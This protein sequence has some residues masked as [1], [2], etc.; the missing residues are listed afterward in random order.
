M[1]NISVEELKSKMDSGENFRLV[2]VREPQ[3]N[4]EYNIG[5]T[6]LPLGNIMGMQ[7]DPIENYK[8][9]EVILYCRSGNRSGQAAM[10]LE[11]MGFKNV[12]NLA[13]GMLAW[14]ERIDLGQ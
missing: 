8:D 1:Q 14:K 12:K 11:T 10:F 3:E 9:D 2:D 6:L 5:G 13:G 7:I 4:A